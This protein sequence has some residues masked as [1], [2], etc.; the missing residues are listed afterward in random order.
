MTV[1][2]EMSVSF[3]SPYF[4]SYVDKILLGRSVARCCVTDVQRCQVAVA[5]LWP[6][7]GHADNTVPA[8]GGDTGGHGGGQATLASL[9]VHSLS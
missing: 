9:T 1:S 2:M 7:F 3:Y 6:L 8:H 5:Q 4:M